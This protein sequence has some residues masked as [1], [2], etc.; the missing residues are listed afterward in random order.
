MPHR[1]AS[2]RLTVFWYSKELTVM[3]GGSGVAGASAVTIEMIPRL[4]TYTIMFTKVG[5]T[6]RE[7][8]TR[9]GM[10][11]QNPWKHFHIITVHLFSGVREVLHTE[12]IKRPTVS[13]VS[14][15]ADIEVQLAEICRFVLLN[16]AQIDRLVFNGDESKAALISCWR[17]LTVQLV[18]QRRATFKKKAGLNSTQYTELHKILLPGPGFDL[19]TKV[20]WVLST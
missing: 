2:S 7:I 13:P 11:S 3:A 12:P 4:V 1:G 20:V 6:P 9:S 19:L 18:L 15:A 14:D 8:R 10:W 16:S 5:H 17:F